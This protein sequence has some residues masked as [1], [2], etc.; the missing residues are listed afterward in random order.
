MDCPRAITK[1]FSKIIIGKLPVML[2]SSI[3]MS[4]TDING[5]ASAIDMS[6][7]LPKV[8]KK[9]TTAY[10]KRKS[11]VISTVNRH[12]SIFSDFNKII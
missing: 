7:N 2:E 11:I 9:N 12:A 4:N 8:E 3:F 6:S 5:N 10:M 1:V